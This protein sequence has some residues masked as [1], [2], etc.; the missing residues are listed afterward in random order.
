MPHLIH[1]P[2]RP[3]QRCEDLTLYG[4]SIGDQGVKAGLLRKKCL[5]NA[6]QECRRSLQ[7]SC[8]G[9]SKFLRPTKEA[10][11]LAQ[12][13]RLRPFW[14]QVRVAAILSSFFPFPFS[15]FKE[16]RRQHK[17]PRVSRFKMPT[18]GFPNALPAKSRLKSL[19]RCRD[20]SPSCITS[21]KVPHRMP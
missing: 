6:F 2:A 5:T 3:R 13:R 17:P 4:N 18:F 15:S 9:N 14:E 8:E 7:R 12:P 21:P 16:Y 1:T 19:C 11:L 10:D 20:A